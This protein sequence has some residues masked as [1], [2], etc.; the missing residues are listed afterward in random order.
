M[1]VMVRIQLVLVIERAKQRNQKECEQRNLINSKQHSIFEKCFFFFVIL[2]R[3]ILKRT[4][5][6]TLLHL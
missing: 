4:L 3:L 2:K 1:L 6:K 5:K